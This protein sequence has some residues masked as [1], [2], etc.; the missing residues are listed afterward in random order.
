[1]NAATRPALLNAVARTFPHQQWRPTTES[2]APDEARPRAPPL[3]RL[4]AQYVTYR[5][6]SIPPPAAWLVQHP[7]VTHDRLAAAPVV[8]V[9]DSDQHAEHNE[10]LHADDTPDALA[11]ASADHY[12]DD[13]VATSS[14]EWSPASSSPSSSP[15]PLASA[16]APP[17]CLRA[18]RDFEVRGFLGRGGFG[19]VYRA[20]SLVDGQDYALK[21]VPLPPRNEGGELP[22]AAAA[23]LAE[24][25]THASLP[26]HAN[27]MRY[28]CAWVEP[29]WEANGS[30][31]DGGGGGGASIGGSTSASSGSSSGSGGG[32]GG[33]GACA[34]ADSADDGGWSALPDASVTASGSVSSTLGRTPSRALG[35]QRSQSHRRPEALY[36]VLGLC[37]G[38]LADWLEERSKLEERSSGAPAAASDACSSSDGS[39]SEGG[40]RISRRASTV[41]RIFR[42]VALG[43]AALHSVGVEHLDLSPRNVFKI[44]SPRTSGLAPDGTC[45]STDDGEA[46]G[47]GDEAS[48]E[49]GWCVGDFGLS[50]RFG[51]PRMA[52][53]F[54]YAAPELL[55]RVS[56]PSDQDAISSSSSS[57]FSSP[58]SSP[59][60]FPSSS[61]PTAAAVPGSADVFSLG[62]L[63]A[64]LS[65]PFATRM[66]RA[67][68]L[69]SLKTCPERR[70][71]GNVISSHHARAAS[72]LA[73]GVELALG[74]RGRR[75]VAAMAHRDPR[76]RPSARAVLREVD[77]LL[78]TLLANEGG[79]QALGD[80]ADV[81]GHR[82]PRQEEWPTA[83]AASVPAAAAT[84]A[85]ATAAVETGVVAAVPRNGVGLAA[86][87]A[88][89]L[90]AAQRLVASLAA[91]LAAAQ[92]EALAT[93]AKAAA[94]GEPGF[95]A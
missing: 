17:V 66:H 30:I 43:V 59:P 1:M 88:S 38:T 58:S 90:A 39:S 93:A 79:G 27:L 70:G 73:H 82:A 52:G 24:A 61:P 3:Q 51:A 7:S 89:E 57:T 48:T 5:R 72:E 18:R 77:Q 28:F 92:D 87:L 29:L 36:L 71:H 10:G 13:P 41:L 16:S 80:R 9:L 14:S 19:H 2:Q 12:C 81:P 4:A 37:E 11:P 56:D 78:S 49:G 83:A 22:A 45:C 76:R 64:E 62:V 91:S 33:A 95:C 23:V 44:A 67:E 25:R 8:E 60:S 31:G 26:P 68:A 63:L 54:L 69:A 42:S 15:A 85:A 65:V 40:R 84:A 21:V 75:L 55:P 6:S 34:I 94:N 35:R 53:T 32:G 74:A 86:A 20:S 50:A 47:A 46:A